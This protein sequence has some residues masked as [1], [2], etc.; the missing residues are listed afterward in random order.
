[1]SPHNPLPR[2]SPKQ[3]AQAVRQ[4]LP[5]KQAIITWQAKPLDGEFWQVV[6]HKGETLATVADTVTEPKI[7]AQD[8]AQLMA[9]APLLLNELKLT[10]NALLAAFTMLSQQEQFSFEK[11]IPL[12]SRSSERLTLLMKYRH[13]LGGVQ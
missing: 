11:L 8:A 9:D 4:R 12:S 6:T 10:H 1:V 2:L 7:S 13:L 3:Y 5:V